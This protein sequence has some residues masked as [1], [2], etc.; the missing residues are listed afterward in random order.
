V[1]WE[2]IAAIGQIVSA[3]AVIA[4]LFYLATQIRESATQARRTHHDE[5]MRQAS[6]VRMAIA[7]NSQLA[8]VIARGAEGY[9]S[10][11]EYERLQFEAWVNERFAAYL[12]LW[13]RSKTARFDTDAWNRVS[14]SFPAL[15]KKPGVLY[16]WNQSK[17]QYPRSFA[18]EIDS[19]MKAT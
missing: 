8:E 10:L 14:R 12:Q 13:D 3:V 19:I 1:N 9:E 11:K 2:A 7:Q 4:T 6:V 18:A 17:A 15:L 16:C 5:T